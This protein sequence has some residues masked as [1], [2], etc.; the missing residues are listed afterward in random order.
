MNRSEF[1]TKIIRL[2]LF[3]AIALISILLGKKVVYGA[4]C[5]SCPGQVTCSGKQ[6][7]NWDPGNNSDK[8]ANAIR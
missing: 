6:A 3:S 7:C 5:S 1:V 2:V 8:Q 4:D